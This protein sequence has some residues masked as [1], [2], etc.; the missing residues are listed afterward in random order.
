MNK[1]KNPIDLLTMIDDYYTITH[2]TNGY[3]IDIGGRD[4]TDDF[5]SVKVVVLNHGELVDKLI[6]IDQR[7][8][9]QRERR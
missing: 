6:E 8:F 7:I 1:A 4:S 2:C 5:S 3:L 9:E